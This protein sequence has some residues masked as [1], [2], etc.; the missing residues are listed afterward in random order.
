[1]ELIASYLRLSDKHL[2]G[3]YD[4]VYI[5]GRHATWLIVRVTPMSLQK[6]IQLIPPSNC[7]MYLGDNIMPTITSALCSMPNL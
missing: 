1:M 6:L 2:D 7:R 4:D 5:P 3:P